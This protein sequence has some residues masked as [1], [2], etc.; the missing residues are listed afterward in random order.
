MPAGKISLERAK[1]DKLFYLVANVIVRRGDGRC[2]ILK[3]ASEEAVHGGQ[4]CFPGGKLE[5]A[6]L[7]VNRPTRVN[8]DVLDFEDAVEKLVARE[9]LEEAGLTVGS[10]LKYVNSVAYIRAD[11]VPS[12][13]VKFV[14][15]YVS[16]EV[17]LEAGGF[18]DF[19]WVNAEEARGYECIMGMAEEIEKAEGL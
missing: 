5:W 7:P 8:G 13:L 2:L 11:G 4:W 14:A 16:G 1:Q 17:R 18:T 6:D 10:D 3:R 19:A 9:A 12:L 15:P